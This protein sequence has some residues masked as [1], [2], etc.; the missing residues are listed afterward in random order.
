MENNL[1]TGK[2]S[3]STSPSLIN[4]IVLTLTGCPN[5]KSTLESTVEI[6]RNYQFLESHHFQLDLVAGNQRLT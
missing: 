6:H 1:V 2:A 4:L 3:D 5:G